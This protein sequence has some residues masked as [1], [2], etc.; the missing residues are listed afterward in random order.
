[1]VC[2][3]LDPAIENSLVK[4][5]AYPTVCD[6]YFYLKFMGAI[7]LIITLFIKFTDE[8]KFVKSDTISAMGV[9]ALAVIFLSLM[10]ATIGFIQ[11]DVFIEIFVS[12][13]VFVV[14]WLLKR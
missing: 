9:S 13:M 4:I 14:L 6:Y 1:M 11:S 5:L 2:R 3:V 8:E 12:G 10:G 7:W